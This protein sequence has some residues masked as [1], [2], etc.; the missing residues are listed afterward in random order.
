[1]QPIT[2]NQHS[3]PTTGALTTP[4]NELRKTLPLRVLSE[5]DWRHWTEHGYVIV[6]QAVPADKVT[7]LVDLLWRFDEKDPNDPAT[8]DAPQRRDHAMAE[9]NHT[10]MLEIYNHQYLWDTRTDPR[11]YDAFV[12]IWDR[13]DL[14]VTIDRANL[15]LP[16]KAKGNSQGFIHWDVDTT[17]RP[18]PIG[19]QGV[20][21]LAPQD[22]EVGG[23]QCVPELFSAFEAWERTQPAGRDP[24]HPD[25][26]GLNIVSVPMD[27]GDL[28]IFN[29]LLA[30]GVRPN[31]SANRPRIAQYI[32]MHPAD[33]DNTAE[34]EERI[35]LWRE[36]DHP[37][38]PAFP[39]DPREWERT[40]AH[41]ATL[42]PLGERLLGLQRW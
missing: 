42:T 37:Q 40:H 2:M 19:V 39:G 41:V 1:M 7:R 15:N 32:S 25:T 26:T 9:L 34:R 23:F 30:H 17:L 24:M 33:W 31:H 14:W 38:R 13:E 22:E 20:L 12:D 21:S 6:R 10:G 16:G 4:L 27:A 5:A 29:S 35:R 18:L 11:V 3:H 36:L 28:L 8:W